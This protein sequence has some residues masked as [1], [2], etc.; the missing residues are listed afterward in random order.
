MVGALGKSLPL[1]IIK[2][3]QNNVPENGTNNTTFI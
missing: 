3:K 1:H 2:Q